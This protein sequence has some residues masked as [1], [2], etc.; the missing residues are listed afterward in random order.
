[1]TD[2]AMLTVAASL[3][4]TMFGLLCALL[5][6][7]GNRLYNKVDEMSNSLTR[8]A[9]ELHTRINNIDTRVVAVETKLDM[10]AHCSTHPGFRVP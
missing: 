2:H 6:W 10:G 7:L 9:G 1:M 4:A 3:V 5:A 8:M